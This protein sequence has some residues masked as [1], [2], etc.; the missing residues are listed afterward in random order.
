MV[1]VVVMAGDGEVRGSEDGAPA[2]EVQ[3]CLAPAAGT[4]AAQ[5]LQS[6]NLRHEHTHSA[7]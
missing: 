6:W 2:C 1:L 7:L 3:G 4:P 5:W